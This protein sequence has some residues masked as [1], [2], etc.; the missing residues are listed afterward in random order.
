LMSEILRL[1]ADFSDWVKDNKLEFFPEYTDHG[2]EHIQSVLN[3]AE[4]IISDSSWD[5][6]TPEDVYVLISSIFLHDSAM[7]LD[8]DG[9]WSLLKNDRFNAPIQV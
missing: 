2:I 1:S 8:K 9:L 5:I 3:T 7:H 4:E 6:I